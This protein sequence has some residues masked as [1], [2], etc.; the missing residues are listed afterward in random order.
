MWSQRGQIWELSGIVA[1]HAGHCIAADGST[2][3]ERG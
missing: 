2:V 1:L 3:A